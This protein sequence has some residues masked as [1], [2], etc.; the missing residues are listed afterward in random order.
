[1][2]CGDEKELWYFVCEN[3][4]GFVRYGVQSITGME[5]PVFPK[6]RFQHGV[7]NRS[8]IESYFPKSDLEYRK[9]FLSI[10]G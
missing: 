5:M 8:I 1:L 3:D 6:R 2:G 9:E 7:G 10:Y 4:A